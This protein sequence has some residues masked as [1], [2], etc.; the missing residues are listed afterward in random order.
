MLKSIATV[1][2]WEVEFDKNG[3]VV[4]DSG[5]VADFAGSGVRDLFFFSH[6]WNNS[7]NGA[8]DLYQD[9]YTKIAGMLTPEQLRATGFVGVLWP[10]LLFPDDGPPDVGQRAGAASAEAGPA[11]VEAMAAPIASPAPT[12]SPTPA[13]PPDPATGAELAAALA[14][15]FPGQEA[16]LQRLGSLLD[17]QPQDGAALDEFYR[18]A[19]GLVTTDETGGPEDNGERA[20][21]S[22]TPR[23][24][25]EAMAGLPGSPGDAQGL[26]FFDKIW[27]GARELLRTMS[28]YEMKNRAGAIGERGLGPLLGTLREKNGQLRAHLLGHSFGARLAAF[29]LRGLPAS[30]VGGSSPVKSLLLIQAAFSH[31][32]FSPAKPGALAPVANRVDGPLVSTFS[33]HDRAV[34]TWYPAAS[35]LAGQDAQFSFDLVFRW[36]GLGHDGFQQDSVV[37]GLLEHQG[38]GYP[39]TKGGFHRLDGSA[40]INRDL[41][42]F[43]GAHC[44][45]QHP[46]VTWAAV[47]AAAL[48]S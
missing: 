42:G 22:A 34:G 38:F 14:H 37:A 25:L 41:S 48:G 19:T 43:S 46:E 2:Y 17:S 15:A 9:M 13:V 20:V 12:E 11:G 7:F 21:L 36:G 10:S 44:D 5:L 6:G 4:A 16:D 24:A 45:I 47:S 39:W 8:R 30:A 29:G 18:L 33:V 28:Y 27:H 40:V 23:E 1:P 31:F 35:A 3:S 32:A 26:A